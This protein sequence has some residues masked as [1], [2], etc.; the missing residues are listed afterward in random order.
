MINDNPGWLARVRAARQRCTWRWGTA[1]TPSPPTS[2]PPGRSPTSPCRTCGTWTTVRSRESVLEAIFLFIP[3]LSSWS[4]TGGQGPYP[5]T[6]CLF[7]V[8]DS[9]RIL[10][11]CC[12]LYKYFK[13]ILYRYLSVADPGC[14]SWIRFFFHPGSPSKNLSV[15]T[16]TNCF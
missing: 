13:N 12:K 1:I 11:Y 6:L 15:L 10:L 2:S 7:V 14:L 5:V 9:S 16:P 3:I 4:A 8:V